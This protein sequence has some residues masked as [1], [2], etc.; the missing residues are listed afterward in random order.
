MSRGS[1]AIVLLFTLGAALNAVPLRTMTNEQ[2]LKW[3]L[4]NPADDTKMVEKFGMNR[5]SVQRTPATNGVQ[6][7]I[8]LWSPGE[9]TYKTIQINLQYF[10]DPVTGWETLQ[11]ISCPRIPSQVPTEVKDCVHGKETA[12]KMLRLILSS[13]IQDPQIEQRATKA[14]ECIKSKINLP[15]IELNCF[16]KTLTQENISRLRGEMIAQLN[17]AGIDIQNGRIV[18]RS[19]LAK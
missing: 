13:K 7:I 10:R 11:G 18:R 1:L 15:K 2:L 9:K 8:E 16:L 3:Y 5:I 12:E 6:K 4:E 19:T 14:A 17:A